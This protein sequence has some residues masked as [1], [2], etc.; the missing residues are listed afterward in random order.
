MKQTYFAGKASRVRF[1]GQAKPRLPALDA[2]PLGSRTGRGAVVPH[3]SRK[4]RGIPPLE[5]QKHSGRSFMFLQPTTESRGARAIGAA[6]KP[7]HL[8][9]VGR[10]SSS[11]LKVSSIGTALGAKEYNR[12][13]AEDDANDSWPVLAVFAQSLDLS[14]VV[15]QPLPWARS[16]RG[17]KAL[18]PRR[19]V[20]C[21]TFLC[22]DCCSAA[23]R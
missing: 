14:G 5:G 20:D 18:L 23:C 15:P 10:R 21:F 13:A 17:L 22:H 8:R 2:E 4:T 19:A 16:P 12:P 6:Q 7:R 3:G 1:A 9:P 11:A